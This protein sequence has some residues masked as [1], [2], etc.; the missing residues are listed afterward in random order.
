M[1]AAELAELQAWLG[2]QP[3]S[4]RQTHGIDESDAEVV[5]LCDG[6]YLAVSVDSIADELVAGIYRDPYTAGWVAATAGLADVAAVGAEPVGVVWATAWAPGWGTAD[7]ARAAAGFGDALREC[8]TC[9]LGGDTG[10]A[11]S[12]VLST[13]AIGCSPEPP[14]SRLGA[15]AGD[16]LCV[17]GRVGSGPALAARALLDEPE[18]AYPEAAFRPRA[19]LAEG[20]HL[21]PLASACTDE[22]D[23][24]VNAVRAL[25][26][27]G[28]LGAELTWDPGLLD[29]RAAAWFSARGLPL[30]LLWIAE[31]GDYEL[32]AAV[33]PDV[34][35]RAKEAVPG[36]T[37]VGRLT[38]GGGV[39][40]HAPAGAV[41]LDPLPSFAAAPPESR[42]ALLEQAVAR[43]REQGLP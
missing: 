27:P 25:A 30:S 23:G 6:L 29:P 10:S 41:A 42:A 11:D 22:S 12:T 8:G 32:V 13:T 16:L 24:L 9:L 18:D 43:M 14:M 39:T 2:R 37:A 17:T 3:R 34:W 40:L 19:R 31:I 38:E 28:G 33:A 15:R 36:L 35:P 5:R 20:V 26:A 21:R 4:P 1:I 7:R